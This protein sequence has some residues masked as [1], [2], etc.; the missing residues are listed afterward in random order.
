MIRA[1]YAFDNISVYEAKAPCDISKIPYKTVFPKDGDT[2]FVYK[3]KNNVSYPT[4]VSKYGDISELKYTVSENDEIYV[5]SS[6]RKGFF[7]IKRTKKNQSDSLIFSAQI[8][9]VL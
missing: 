3:R 1:A 9:C 8:T 4:I 2:V 6:E 5:E 7:G